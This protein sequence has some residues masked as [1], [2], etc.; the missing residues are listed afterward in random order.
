MVSSVKSF[1]ISWAIWAIPPAIV[2]GAAYAL[3]LPPLAW[4]PVWGF[5]VAIVLAALDVA[6]AV[7]DD[8]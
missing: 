6:F 8:E 4:L 7:E 1:L 3:D 5:V 2:W